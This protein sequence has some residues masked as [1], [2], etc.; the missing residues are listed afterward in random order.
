MDD[1]LPRTPAR[2]TVAPMSTVPIPTG[3]RSKLSPLVIT[4]ISIGGVLVLAIVALLFLLLGRGLG[5]PNSAVVGQSSP[6]PTA[7]SASPSPAVEEPV[8]EEPAEDTTPRFTSFDAQTQVECPNSGDK[9]E[10]MFSWETAYAVEVWYTSGH[11]DA[12]VD[13]YMQVP[14][15][16]SQNDLTDE[17]LFPC[18]HR[19][20]EDYTVTL[21]G[22][23]GEHVS[24]Y[25]TVTD[26]NW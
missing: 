16:G 25:F 12:K 19:Q 17:H 10:I 1:R 9:P 2:D 18:A 15:S 20:S 26:L 24:E 5:D 22:A 6:V 4:L 8:A 11:E 3:P 13:N 14:L 7:T 23:N 21:V